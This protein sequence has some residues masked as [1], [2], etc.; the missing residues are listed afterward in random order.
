MGRD[1]TKLPGLGLDRV[2]HVAEVL[3]VGRSIRLDNRI[4]VL[5]ELDNLMKIWV[6]PLHPRHP[7]HAWKWCDTT[8][9]VW[10]VTRS[11]TT[12]FKHRVCHVRIK[13]VIPIVSIIHPVI[14]LIIPIVSFMN[15][16]TPLMVSIYPIFMLKMRT[17]G[18]VHGGPMV[19]VCYATPTC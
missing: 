6:P 4:G 19:T 3:Q 13:I 9:V 7:R 17:G 2:V 11:I 15:P 14:P 18:M 12:V 16:I 8:R 10:E 1:P 5:Q